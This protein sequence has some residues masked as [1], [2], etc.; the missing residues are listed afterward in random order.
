MTYPLIVLST[1]DEKKILI[2]IK[3][4]LLIYIYIHI[5]VYMCVCVCIYT[6][7]YL[8]YNFGVFPRVYCLPQSHEYIS[9]SFSRGIII[10]AAAF[11]F[12]M[13]PNLV[14]VKAITQKNFFNFC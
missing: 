7:I 13:H 12:A 11:R 6:Y 9:I 5:Y 1:F 14:F 4:S 2:L 10:L 3:S 8:L